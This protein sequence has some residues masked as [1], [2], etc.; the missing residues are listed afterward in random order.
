MVWTGPIKAKPFFVAMAILLFVSVPFYALE[1]F[2]PEVV[3][4]NGVSFLIFA[5]S[6]LCEG[7]FLIVNLVK[8][9]K[10]SPAKL[11]MDMARYELGMN[12]IVAFSVLSLA[13]I[14]PEAPRNWLYYF[15]IGLTAVLILARLW[16]VVWLQR[17]I[18][19]GDTGYLPFRNHGY[20]LM[21]LSFVAL[22]YYVISILKANNVDLAIIY[23][24]GHSFAGFSDFFLMM[25]VLEILV[26]IVVLLQSLFISITTYY[27]SKEDK[28][29]DLRLNLEQSKHIL[30]E[31][32]VPFWI[33]IFA[34]SLM[35]VLA[36][37]SM[38]ASVEAYAPITFLFLMVLIIRLLF[39]FGITRV[40]RKN[41]GDKQR[42][43]KWEHIIVLVAALFFALYTVLVIL[44]GQMAFER[45]GNVAYTVFLTF[46]VFLPWAL[47]KLVLGAMHYAKARKN[48]NP[49]ALTNA[50]LD[51]LLSIYTL[52]QTFAIIASKARM[53]G[54]RIAAI[55]VAM[56]LSLYCLYVSIRMGI[57]GVL[58]LMGKRKK[59]LLLF[60][61][62][63]NG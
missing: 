40:Q 30:A 18:K 25:T 48:G 52:A 37:V 38:T 22:N 4:W 13:T 56:V 29:I 2:Y 5:L 54:F 9:D 10:V 27:S 41:Q 36:L 55:V 16:A 51:I 42:I 45:M 62:E 58:G 1:F 20:V 14:F 50:F 8:M 63:N 53:E 47:V 28:V 15:N 43:F 23:E 61:Q 7:V 46:G 60:E 34:L 31:K 57:V 12:P 6:S 49:A 17:A 3:G 19:K 35:L 59:A 24:G 32:H 21:S 11:G 26:G 33:G 44:F 39:H